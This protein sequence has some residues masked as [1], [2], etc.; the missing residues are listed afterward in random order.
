MPTRNRAT[1]VGRLLRQLTEFDDHLRYE[2]IVI[3]EGSSDET[4]PL[5]AALAEAHGV[6]V[7]HHDVPLGL[8]AARNA[9]LHMANSP[10]VAWIDDDDLTAPDRL[11]RQHRALTERGGGWSFTARVDIDDELRVVGH[12]R[13]IDTDDFLGAILRINCVPTSAQGL[14]VERELALSVGGYDESLQSAE[15]WD[16]CIRLAVR[17]APHWIDEPLVAYRTGVASMSTDTRRMDDA[18]DTMVDK[19]AN[20]YRTCGIAPDWQAIHESLITADLMG[21]R[22]RAVR[23]AG[24][25]FRARPSVRGAMRIPVIAGAPRWFADRSAARRSNQVPDGWRSQTREWLDRVNAPE[26]ASR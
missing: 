20:L 25:S 5:L 14:L 1:L 2:V 13:C 26:E 21:G 17:A 9:G 15:D 6:R 4:G 11:A 8:P 24:R 10:Y 7:A 12:R 23:R 22:W 3:D 18:I 16:F 19:H